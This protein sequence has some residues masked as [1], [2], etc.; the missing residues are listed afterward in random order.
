MCTILLERIAAVVG[1]RREGGNRCITFCV[2]L[3]MLQNTPHEVSSISA[4]RLSYT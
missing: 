3:W 2:L 1:Q 4:V